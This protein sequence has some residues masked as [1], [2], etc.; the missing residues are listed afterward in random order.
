[1]GFIKKD[2]AKNYTK[3]LAYGLILFTIAFFISVI[4]GGTKVIGINN[5]INFKLLIV[6][7]LGFVLQGMS[8][9]IFCRGYLMISISRENS[10]TS[11]VI[12]Q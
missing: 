3:G 10:V 4:L 8:E 7:F 2:I 12:C 1:M 6:I 11:A 5:Q 9:E